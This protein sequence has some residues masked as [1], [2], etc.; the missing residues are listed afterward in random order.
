MQTILP[1]PGN[2]VYAEQCRLCRIQCI[3]SYL[4]GS[5]LKVER[6][7]PD[8]KLCWRQHGLHDDPASR[9]TG[10]GGPYLDPGGSNRARDSRSASSVEALDL[11]TP[12]DQMVG[13]RKK[14]AI[15]TECSDQ[16]AI[17]ALIF[18]ITHPLGLWSIW[19]VTSCQICAFPFAVDDSGCGQRDR[20]HR[21]NSLRESMEDVWRT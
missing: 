1:V 3:I 5:D 8:R 12:I 6:S 21:S 11:T 4:A 9:Q 15:P 7:A 20:D 18:D 13:A 2:S 14:S 19:T 10:G 17:G 16:T